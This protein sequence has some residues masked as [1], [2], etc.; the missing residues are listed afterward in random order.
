VNEAWIKMASCA[1]AKFENTLHFKRVA[2][3][4][5]RQVLVDTARRKV[6]QRRG[7]GEAT[8]FVTFSEEVC[9]GASSPLGV[10]ALDQ[11]LEELAVKS[12]RQAEVAMLRIFQGMEIGEIATALNVSQITVSRD[13]RVIR[14][15]LA[16]QLGPTATP[17]SPTKR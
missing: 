13:W 8:S 10:L 7:G 16:V 4:A 11:T 2:A 6:A 3:R 15:W 5:M 14:A 17:E 9:G 12:P 1:D